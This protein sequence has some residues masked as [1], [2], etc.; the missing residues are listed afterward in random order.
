MPFN[1]PI[2]AAIVCVDYADLL[3]LTLPRNRPHFEQVLIVTNEQD[4]ATVELAINHKCVVYQTDAFY[5]NGAVFNKWLALE[6]GL[7][8]F[9]RQ[10][11]M[12]MLDADTIW[13]REIPD[14]EL[15]VGK[16]YSP[17]RHMCE[18]IPK[19]SSGSPLIPSEDQWARYPIHRNIYEWAGYTQ[20]FHARDKVLQGSKY[21]HE[22]NWRHAGG[23]DSFFQA[24]WE[25]CNKI[26]PPFNVLHLGLAGVNWCGRAD[27]Y[28]DGTVHP[29]A[30]LRRKQVRDFVCGRTL[31]PARFDKEKII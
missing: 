20:I 26:R 28:A 21:W 25:T 30:E 18:E 29:D 2:R 3:A 27:R 16:L 19:S 6:E 24:K 8:R 9:G 13:P 11:W 15:E 22:V 4:K 12:C 23:A 1:K 17:L 31:G 10:D 7:D 14:I 5:R